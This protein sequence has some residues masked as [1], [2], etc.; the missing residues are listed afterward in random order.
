MA[1]L[2]SGETRGR[3]LRRA[4]AAKAAFAGVALT[5]C[6]L[7]LL[8][9]QAPTTPT[10]PQTVAPPSV[11]SV[12]TN[13]ILVRVVVRDGQGNA[14]AGLSQSDFQVIDN[15]KSQP[16]A[17]F[18]A[19]GGTAQSAAAGAP[20]AG[21]SAPGSSQRYTALFFDDYHLQ[22][23]DLSR[24]FR[25]AQ[26][27]VTKA[28]S[29]GDQV[30]IFTPSGQVE[31]DF[32]TDAE[33]LQKALSQLRV[34][35][36]TGEECPNLTPYH[37]QLFLD[38]EPVAVQDAINMTAQCICNGPPN[39]C[40]PGINLPLIAQMTARNIL[41]QSDMF[42]ENTLGALRKL[43]QL[44]AQLPGE[45]RIGLISNGFEIRDHEDRLSEIIDGA[46]RSNVTISAMTG[47]GLKAYVPGGDASQ[48]AGGPDPNLEKS[49]DD[50]AAAVVAETTEGTGG[51]FIHDTNDFD[52]GFER[53]GGVAEASYV[54][55]FSPQDLKFDGSIHK[56]KTVVI[57][58]SSWTIEARRSYVATKPAAPVVTPEM[59]EQASFMAILEATDPDQQ[60]LLA[61]H[62]LAAHPASRFAGPASNR[63]VE[64]C[65]TKKDWVDFYPAAATTLEKNPDDVDVLVLTGWVIAHLYDPNEPTAAAKYDQAANY[66]KHALQIIPTLPKPAGL[67]DEQ[68]AAYKTTETLRAHSGLGLVD[69]RRRDF[70]D[71]VQELQQVTAGAA[72]PDPTDLWALGVGLRQLKRYADATAVFEKCGQFPGN[73]QT[74]CQ[75]LAH[76]A[77]ADQAKVHEAIWTPPDVDAPLPSLS[78]AQ[79][80]SLPDVLAQAAVRAQ[81][82]V[83][84][85]QRFSAQEKV[86][87][88]QL[89]SYGFLHVTETATYDYVVSFEQH[90]GSLVVDESRQVSAG[91]TGLSGGPPNRGLPALAL[92]FHPFYQGD[93]DMRCEG[94]ADW[95]G[96]PAWVIYFI[97]RKDKP[98][99]T[100]GIDTPQREFSLKLKG[101]AWIAA[102]SYQ[103]LHLETNLVEPVPMLGL[104]SDA[105][106]ISY[107]PVD[108]HA[109][110]VQLWL[111]QSAITFAEL[112]NE[113]TVAKHAFGD[114]VLFSVDT[115]QTVGPPH[116]PPQR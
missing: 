78:T 65:Y 1:K 8:A 101:R 98:S 32:T 11:I 9:A 40:A 5:A 3:T 7:A 81:E 23:G 28:L 72:P 4:R 17:Y 14:V 20:T 104:R 37:A 35:R 67:T 114:F 84:N 6:S 33:K 64:A 31:I 93:Y 100:E 87:F 68:F 60:I 90:A 34:A 50:S 88:Q 54:L 36:G 18:S 92:I 22:P 97:Q 82:L 52:G 110:N 89:D 75:Q 38:N 108:F 24:T 59:Q 111:P 76:Q 27:L 26:A 13:L 79:T 70:G 85:L 106:S 56:L 107:A 115:N 73:L 10:P 44:M 30:G 71:S 91:G 58:H 12:Q 39:T 112:G 63:L 25:P 94:L 80:C 46:I 15:G 95:E 103:V 116:Q 29:A 57:E 2:L 74:P 19:E 42:A 113:R 51:V 109:Q 49:G 69:L 61:Q 66:L 41:A 21:A 102:D 99:R 43:V 77:E 16:I 48:S 47:Y 96:T 45:H 105:S 55:G 83:A 86:Q 62:F 53:I